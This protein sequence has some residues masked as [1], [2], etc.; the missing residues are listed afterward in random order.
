MERAADWDAEEVEPWRAIRN[1]I[2]NSSAR[3][4]EQEEDRRQRGLMK[5]EARAA[6][7][8]G[9][10]IL[11]RLLQAVEAGQLDRLGVPDLLPHLQKV[12]TLL[13]AG[14][15]LERLERGEVTD[16][17]ETQVSRD[18]L[19]RQIAAILLEAVAAKQLDLQALA[20]VRD[21]LEAMEP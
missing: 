9:R 8:V 10:R 18:G 12:A 3:V 17:T 6:R 13:E 21:D 2:A 11:L 4:A 19:G 1:W 20:A 14:Q 15:K 16:R 7:A 5:E